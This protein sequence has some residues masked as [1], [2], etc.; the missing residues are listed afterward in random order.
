MIRRRPWGEIAGRPLARM[1]REDLA[2]DHAPEGVDEAG[3]GMSP[4]RSMGQKSGPGG[5]PAA[6]STAR[7]S[8]A[9]RR[10]TGCAGCDIPRTLE[11]KATKYANKV[12]D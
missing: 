6:S 8:M 9:G 4:L 12:G 5:S 7:G 10:C 3:L 11:H 2:D 1:P